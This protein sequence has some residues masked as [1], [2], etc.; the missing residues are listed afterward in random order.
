MLVRVLFATFLYKLASSAVMDKEVEKVT[1]L[2]FPV[3]FEFPIRNDR[4]DQCWLRIE[5]VELTETL[6][7]Y[8]TILRAFLGYYIYDY[9]SRKMSEDGVDVSLWI[10]KPR[11]EKDAA[12]GPPDVVN[13]V[14]NWRLTT[15]MDPTTQRRLYVSKNA[16][17]RIIMYSREAMTNYVVDCET[18]LYF[19]NEHS[20]S[21]TLS[22][23]NGLVF[24]AFISLY[25]WFNLRFYC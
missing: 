20:S 13:G 8:C 6:A 1:Q 11:R 17:C 19:V 10:E 21:A 2:S 9:N 25:L 15:V 12:Y 7:V 5:D 3:P 4:A 14:K 18:I 23:G 22:R 24:L 16:V